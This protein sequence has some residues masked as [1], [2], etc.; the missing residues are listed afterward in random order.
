MYTRILVAVDG[1]PRAPK[2]LEHA[3]A[4]AERF[5]AKLCLC[6]AVNIPLGLPPDAWTLSGDELVA[7][8]IDAAT[9]ELRQLAAALPEAVRGDIICKLGRPG[10]VIDEAADAW[11]AD[12]VVIGSHGYGPLERVLGT[13]AARV[14][15]HAKRPT[16][17]VR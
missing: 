4:I 3:K 14:V 1:S 5:G 2:V 16:L 11:K 17:V 9:E 10:Q 15:N 7:A 13:T 8:L 12:L 6:R